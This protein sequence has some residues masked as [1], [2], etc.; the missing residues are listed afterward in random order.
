MRAEKEPLVNTILLQNNCPDN[1]ITANPGEM[2]YRDGRTFYKVLNQIDLVRVEVAFKSFAYPDYANRWYAST[3]ENWKYKFKHP[4]ELWIKESGIGTKIGWKFVGFKKL[5]IDYV[6][7]TVTPTPTPTPT[8]SPSSSETPTPSLSAT[9]TPTPTVVESFAFTGASAELISTDDPD[10]L[11]ISTPVNNSSRRTA[12]AYGDGVY[13][14]CG[15]YY[16]GSPYLLKSIDLGK[17]WYAAKMSSELSALCNGGDYG[18]EFVHCVY[19]GNGTFVAVGKKQMI[20]VSTDFGE[21]WEL[22]RYNKD[23]TDD[24]QPVRYGSVMWDRQTSP[25][26]LLRI[27]NRLITTMQCSKYTQ[28]S[29]SVNIV[30]GAYSDD[31]GETWKD[32]D[33][34]TQSLAVTESIFL[35]KPTYA[36]NYRSIAY[37]NGKLITL[38]KTYAYMSQSMS[39]SMWG[40]RI[41]SA[42]STDVGTTW[43]NINLIQ[44]IEN[45][46]VNEINNGLSGYY[47]IGYGESA[48]LGNQLVFGNGKFVGII[49][50][51]YPHDRKSII[52]SDDGLNWTAKKIENPVIDGCGVYKFDYLNSISFNGNKF[53]LTLH[54]TYLR[55]SSG[56]YGINAVVYLTSID[57]IHW[58]SHE[59]IGY[60]TPETTDIIDLHDYVQLPTTNTQIDIGLKNAS[61]NWSSSMAI[62]LTGSLGEVHA[63]SAGANVDRTFNGN[64]SCTS[65]LFWSFLYPND[66][67]VELDFSKSNFSMCVALV[68]GNSSLYIESLEMFRDYK[69]AFNVNANEETKIAVYAFDGMCGD[70][71]FTYSASTIIPN[72][73]TSVETAIELTGSFV[74]VSTLNKLNGDASDVW[75]KW[76]PIYQTGT[77][78]VSASFSPDFLNTDQKSITGVYN[79]HATLYTLSGSVVTQ[80]ALVLINN[81]YSLSDEMRKYCNA[82]ESVYYIKLSADADYPYYGDHGWDGRYQLIISNSA[83]L[84]NT[85][86]ESAST[87]PVLESGVWSDY[88]E[89]TT[90][91]STKK[92]KGTQ[93]PYNFS[94][95][96]WDCWYKIPCKLSG[97]VTIELDNNAPNMKVYYLLQGHSGGLTCDYTNE[98]YVRGFYSEYADCTANK[99]DSFSFA[100]TDPIRNSGAYIRFFDENKTID[101][102]KFRYKINNSTNA[103]QFTQSQQEYNSGYINTFY[104]SQFKID[105]TNEF[106]FNSYY[107]FTSCSFIDWSSINGVVEVRVDLPS[108]TGWLCVDITGSNIYSNSY[109]YDEN[110]TANFIR[111]SGSYKTSF[112][113]EKKG[114]GGSNYFNLYGSYADELNLHIRAIPTS[115][116][117]KTTPYEF[118]GETGS[119]SLLTDGT[120]SSSVWL[121]YVSG[122]DGKLWVNNKSAMYFNGILVFE[123]SSTDY[124]FTGPRESF[125]MFVKSGSYYDMELYCPPSYASP[126][127]LLNLHDFISSGGINI[128]Y[129]LFP[130]ES[131]SNISPATAVNILA[132]EEVRGCNYTIND[133]Y[134][135]W[136]KYSPPTDGV[137]LF[138]CDKLYEGIESA[139][140][141]IVKL[142]YPIGSRIVVR[143]G[144]DYYLKSRMYTQNDYYTLNPS[145]TLYST[146]SV[147]FFEKIKQIGNGNI[148]FELAK[149]VSQSFIDSTTT[150]INTETNEPYDYWYKFINTSSVASLAGGY[151]YYNSGSSVTLY[152]TSG[153]T[154]GEKLQNLQFVSQ[155]FDILTSFGSSSISEE[156]YFKFSPSNN[157][158]Y[159]GTYIQGVI[160]YPPPPPPPPPE[161]DSFYNAIELIGSSGQLTASNSRAT[162]DPEDPSGPNTKR[163]IWY[164]WVPNITGPATISTIGSNFDTYLYLYKLND[165]AIVS[166]SNLTFIASDDDSGGSGTSKIITNL[167]SGSKY[168]IAVGGYNSSY[169][170]NIVL[171]FN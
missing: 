65:T 37:G 153:S 111:F 78:T 64:T 12:I 55:T 170:G 60:I 41:A 138:S 30:F 155:S 142:E 34:T 74:E 4:Y 163:S 45:E 160:A 92:E 33:F 26:S 88:I 132:G 67:Y 57:G 72:E 77:V 80:S 158:C 69:M 68:D 7:M 134:Y 100:V 169:V 171:S 148:S 104:Q 106:P 121:R 9:P 58:E 83:P 144:I 164:T 29:S 143:A 14:S 49:P 107:R 145:G 130:T 79:A 50:K 36:A 112:I 82:T 27:N 114:N 59:F 136:W 165:G 93:W 102:F 96:S 117:F 91:G 128:E 44:Q 139:S 156:F 157:G 24:E 46:D 28:D 3:N 2:L 40:Y 118:Y 123:S 147:I 13:M 53:I 76:S 61:Q 162:L 161:N 17:T 39:Q 105:G 131:T 21:N 62:L 113:Q 73:N 35:S 19:A 32:I 167:T 97:S 126:N 87:L 108:Y 109:R 38:G 125:Y 63:N 116:Y 152:K 120:F 110:R 119:I 18:I 154:V 51:Y 90:V 129:K 5:F 103:L 11:L 6:K 71:N 146:A 86:F 84:H 135:N 22:I 159:G 10:V 70:V 150:L 47:A 75:Y 95:G 52:Y 133:T 42:Y 115:S 23:A 98:T 8:P 56:R 101:E 140:A 66:T 81:Y 48:D 99:G 85:F 127:M 15:G 137:A 122:V 149:D 54:N 141:N 25:T 1:I 31:R 124:L 43:S 94:T 151:S 166:Q 20:I 168:Y 16:Y 89:S